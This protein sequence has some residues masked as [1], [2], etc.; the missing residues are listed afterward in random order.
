MFR[1]N[2]A[3]R[4]RMQINNL[5]QF[6]DKTVTLRMSDGETTRVKVLFVDE[7][8]EVVIAE[9]VE[10]S[11]PEESRAPCA[12]HTFAAE[13]IVSAELSADGMLPRGICFSP[14]K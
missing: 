10:T 7:E 12:R 1:H 6:V 13:H 14:H 11:R 9:V 5:H 4:D 2:A 8:D 3:I